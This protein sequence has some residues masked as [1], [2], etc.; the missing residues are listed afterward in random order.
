MTLHALKHRYV[1]E[2]QW[3]FERLV[4]LVAGVAFAIGHA[5]EVNRVLHGDRLEQCRWTGRIR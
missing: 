4:G 1:A 3:V 2:I 5:A